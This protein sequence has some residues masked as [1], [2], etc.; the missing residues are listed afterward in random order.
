MNVEMGL[1]VYWGKGSQE[2]GN[3]NSESE[4][5]KVNILCPFSYVKYVCIY[6]SISVS[7][8]MT[9]MSMSQGNYLGGSRPEVEDK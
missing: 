1:C 3:E 5:Q 7:M 2:K 9:W 8:S 6:I 4:N